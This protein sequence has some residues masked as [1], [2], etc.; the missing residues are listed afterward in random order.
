MILGK[1]NLFKFIKENPAKNGLTFTRRRLLLGSVAVFLGFSIS[2]RMSKASSILSSPVPEGMDKFMR[3]SASLTGVPSP[4]KN[5]GQIIYQ[6][7]IELN[8]KTPSLVTLL[9]SYLINGKITDNVPLEIQ[10][11]AALINKAR[12]LGIIEEGEHARCVAYEHT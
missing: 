4:A 6:G 7:L 9:Q 5:L 2:G 12:Y 1:S 10:T 8:P 3:I 11:L